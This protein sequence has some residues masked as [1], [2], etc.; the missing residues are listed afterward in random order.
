M[1]VWFVSARRGDVELKVSAD[2]NLT[3]AG[4]AERPQRGVMLREAFRG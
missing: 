4:G 2:A 3:E 1:C